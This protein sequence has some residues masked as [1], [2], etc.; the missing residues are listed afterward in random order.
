MLA[1]LLTELFEFNLALNELLVL[2]GPIGLAR[3]LV[4]DLYE[5]IL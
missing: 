2:A 5:F 4:L 1:E 3:L